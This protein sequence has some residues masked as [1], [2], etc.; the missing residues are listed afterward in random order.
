MHAHEDTTTPTDQNAQPA[1]H[2]PR[3]LVEN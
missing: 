2:T 3:I 1:N